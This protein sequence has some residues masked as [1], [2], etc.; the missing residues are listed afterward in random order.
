MS[1]RVYYIALIVPCV[2]IGVSIRE[3]GVSYIF[4]SA[5]GFRRCSFRL[6]GQCESL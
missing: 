6:T 3:L 4:T 2:A 5:W 1:S